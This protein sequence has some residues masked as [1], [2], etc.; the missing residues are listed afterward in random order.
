MYFTIIIAVLIG[1]Y[2]NFVLKIELKK[3]CEWPN[4]KILRLSLLIIPWISL[5]WLFYKYIEKEIQN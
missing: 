1:L 3:L 5:F 2:M 4:N